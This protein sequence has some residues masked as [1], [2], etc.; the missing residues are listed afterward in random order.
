LDQSFFSLS[1]RE[2]CT[3]L[4]LAAGD[5][6]VDAMK[7]LFLAK[8]DIESQNMYKLLTFLAAIM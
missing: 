8:A 7:A 6:H 4:L 5:G 2:R 3:P 1:R